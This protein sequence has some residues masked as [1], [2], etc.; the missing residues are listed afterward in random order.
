M[1]PDDVYEDCVRV[2]LQCPASTTH[3][4]WRHLRWSAAEMVGSEDVLKA[5]LT[6]AYEAGQRAERRGH[7]VE[8]LVEER[9]G[10]GRR[11]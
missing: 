4:S 5:A 9:F 3:I 6:E 1:L 2:L 7:A 8:A 10:P 11:R